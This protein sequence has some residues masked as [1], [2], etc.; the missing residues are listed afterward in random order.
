MPPPRCAETDDMQAI[1]PLLRSRMC[2]TTA[3]ERFSTPVRLTSMMR[4]QLG[5]S[6]SMNFTGWVMPALLMRMSIFP[7]RSM[8]SAAAARQAPASVTSQTTPTMTRAEALRGRFGR[9][10]F[11][12][13]DRHA[14]AV[15]GEQSRGREARCRAA[16]RLPK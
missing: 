1:E 15:L 16:R 10:G 8:A 9:G 7:S 6:I 14:R 13:E 2:G 4:R 3:C 11:D 5:P 12:I